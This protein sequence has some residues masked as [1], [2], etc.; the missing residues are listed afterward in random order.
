MWA[1]CV[2]EGG[3]LAGTK[4]CNQNGMRC[5][6]VLFFALPALSSNW[7]FISRG[8]RRRHEHDRWKIPSSLLWNADLIMEVQ[9]T[10]KLIEIWWNLKVYFTKRKWTSFIERFTWNKHPFCSKNNCKLIQ[11]TINEFSQCWERKAPSITPNR[12]RGKSRKAMKRW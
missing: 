1:Q 11:G 12:I 5:C 8:G 2:S 3:R 7:H 10:S 9:S 6:I 4:G